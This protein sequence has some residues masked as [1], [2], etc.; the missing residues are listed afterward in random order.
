MLLQCELVSMLRHR[1]VDSLEFHDCSHSTANIGSFI[2]YLFEIV[3]VDAKMKFICFYFYIAIFL[4]NFAKRYSAA[5]GANWCFWFRCRVKDFP[6]V[7]IG[8]CLSPVFSVSVSKPRKCS[9]SSLFWAAKVLSKC[10]CCPVCA[11]WSD[12][13]LSYSHDMQSTIIGTNK[14]CFENLW[15]R[16]INRLMFPS[17]QDPN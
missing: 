6:H 3:S 5:N 4:C 1:T 17:G 14:C 11:F 13:H 10:L 9:V 8:H 15:W 12:V 2:I 16:V 7:V